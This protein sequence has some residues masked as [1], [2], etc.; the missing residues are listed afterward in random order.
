VIVQDAEQFVLGF[1]RG[2]PVEVQ[3]VAENLSSDGGLLA[4]VE[5]DRQLCWT[6]S[7]SRLI[8]DARRNPDHSVLSMVRQRVFGI[9]AGYEDQNDH[10]TLRS[11]PVFKLLADVHPTEGR[12]L[13]SQP[14]LSRLENAVLV[15]DLLAMEEWMLER[16]VETLPGERGEITLDIDT[17]DDPTHG[18]QQ[19]ALFHGF[20]DQYQYQVRVISCAETD[21]LAFPVLL[22]GTAPASLG[23]AEDLQRVCEKIRQRFPD[24]R[25]HVRADSGFACSEIYETLERLPGVTYSI[26]IGIN[27]LTKKLS[28]KTLQTAVEAYDQSGQP[29]RAFVLAEGYRARRW[30]KSRTL[31]I[32]CE[33]TDQGTNRRVVVSNRPGVSVCPQG[34]HDGYAD[35]GESENRN[36]ELKSELGGDRLSDHRYMA[37]L[38]RINMHVLA[39][40]LLVLL[41]MQVADPPP[42]PGPCERGIPLEASSARRKRQAHNH[43]RRQDPLGEGHACTWRMLVIKVAA[44][45]IVSTRRVRIQI[46]ESWPYARYLQQVGRALAADLPLRF[47]G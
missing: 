40:N 3:P 19:L 29:Q 35:R 43:R 18:R 16:F 2:R 5:L 24:V 46:S 39:A 28:E 42:E 15:G 10:D 47:S 30:N 20:Y 31:V 41:R 45:V 34:V 17:F 7:F 9:L 22:Y 23:A 36:K 21:L 14:T 33:A 11:D 6:E 27:P 25:I 44:R 8:S 13:A 38:F 1:W 32:K 4:F 26:G 37:N 12:D